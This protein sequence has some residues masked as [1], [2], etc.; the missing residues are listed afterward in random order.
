MWSAFAALLAG[1][2][3]ADA[4]KEKDQRVLSGM[5]A[6]TPEMIWPVKERLFSPLHP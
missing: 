5:I 6:A 1:G 3:C 2:V 4:V